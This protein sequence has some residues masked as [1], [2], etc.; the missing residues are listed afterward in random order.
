MES[1][2]TASG[3]SV[4]RKKDQIVL[5]EEFDDWALLFDPDTGM[6]CGVNPVGVQAW[7]MIDGKR[8][9]QDISRMIRDSYPDAPD[10][11][12]D[13]ITDFMNEINEKGYVT[14]I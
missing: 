1:S 6:V 9:V 5:R 14:F 13:D 7:M 12:I 3:R 10:S 8:T 4:L 2:K 11:V